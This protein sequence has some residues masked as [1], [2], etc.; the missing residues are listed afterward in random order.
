MHT[1]PTRL[2]STA[3]SLCLVLV[4]YRLCANGHP[5]TSLGLFPHLK[6]QRGAFPRVVV[7]IVIENCI[8]LCKC[9]AQLPL[10]NSHFISVN[11]THARTEY[12]R[13]HV[14]ITRVTMPLRVSLDAWQMH[15]VCIYCT[16][17]L[18]RDTL[19]PTCACTRT[20]LFVLRGRV[21]A[22]LS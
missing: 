7:K 5:L 3:G 19:V 2:H 4:S 13:V 22:L 16:C 1:G 9:E 20:L 18:I 21:C 12:Q 17:T 15:T 8:D 11:R 6:Y 10:T 14:H